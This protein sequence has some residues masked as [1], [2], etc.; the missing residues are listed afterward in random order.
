MLIF[1]KEASK[2]PNKEKRDLFGYVEQSFHMVPGTIADQISLFDEEITK[3][4]IEK[5]A[6]LVGLHEIIMSLPQKNSNLYFP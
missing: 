6:K 3:E 1:G 4:D 5:A 2:I